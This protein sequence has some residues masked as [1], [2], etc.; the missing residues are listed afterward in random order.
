MELELELELKNG[1]EINVAVHKSANS[2]NIYNN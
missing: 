2:Y 1:I